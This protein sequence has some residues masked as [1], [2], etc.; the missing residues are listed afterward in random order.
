M[1]AYKR[2]KKYNF[3]YP[4]DMEKI[5]NYLRKHGE[6]LVDDFMI[7]CLYRKFSDDW[8]CAGWVSVDEHA[9]N[10]F[11]KWLNDYNF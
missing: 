6:I 10:E 7:E 8:Y 4:D 9:L 3:S 1:K 2:Y 11:E 5:L